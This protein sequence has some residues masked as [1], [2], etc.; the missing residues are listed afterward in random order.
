MEAVRILHISPVPNIKS[1]LGTLERGTR[2]LGYK[3]Q[4]QGDN[5]AAAR[6]IA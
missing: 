2:H 4:V 3:V 5:A 6:D 1:Y